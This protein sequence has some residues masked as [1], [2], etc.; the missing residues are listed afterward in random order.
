MTRENSNDGFISPE[1][2]DVAVIMTNSMDGGLIQR[3]LRRALG[4]H[5]EIIG[6]IPTNS[7]LAAKGAASSALDWLKHW[8]KTQ[9]LMDYE[10]LN[11]HKDRLDDAR[12]SICSCRDL[13]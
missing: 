10:R 2:V 12:V 4:D 7:L 5:V 8:E 6:G 3:A 13:A 1:E 11:I 9:R